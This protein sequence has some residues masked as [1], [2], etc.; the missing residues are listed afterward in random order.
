ASSGYYDVLIYS[1]PIFE[2]EEIR[3]SSHGNYSNNG[4]WI[5]VYADDDII[6]P[7]RV[8]TSNEF[9]QAE[10]VT[11]Y[12][13]DDSGQ[14]LG[15]KEVPKSSGIHEIHFSPQDY[16][17]EKQLY[18]KVIAKGQYGNLITEN[19]SKFISVKAPDINDIGSMETT[20]TASAVITSTGESDSMCQMS[21]LDTD[22]KHH[23]MVWPK[24]ELN[25]PS[26]K[27]LIT[28]LFISHKII[29]PTEDSRR[30]DYNDRDYWLTSSGV[31]G[32]EGTLARY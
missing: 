23:F 4:D 15:E 20:A 25:I 30:V 14:S 29:N 13:F 8:D 9:N 24:T 18:F 16:F 12:L 28:Q 1:Q 21:W 31:V 27:K 6:L 32:Y 22:D 26:N 5:P 17:W 3:Y 11:V 7:L 2:L 19:K 10:S